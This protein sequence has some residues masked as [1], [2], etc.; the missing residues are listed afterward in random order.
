MASY[1]DAVYTKPNLAIVADG[2]NTETLS[3]WVNQFFKDVPA[4]SQS[5]QSLKTEATKYF[6]GEQ[7]TANPAGNSMVIAFPGSDINGSKPEIA[8]LASLLG[9]QPSVKWTAGFSLLSKAAATTPGLSASA[10]SLAYS[11][12]G[13]LAIQLTGA[14]ASVRKGAQD[15]VQA[16][17]SVAQ[18]SVSKEDLTKAIANA[19]FDALDKAQLRD[20]SILLAGNGI[21]NGGKPL[22]I[23]S[24]SQTFDAVTADKLT[25]VS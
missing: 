3:R 23:A 18:G 15:T 19:K 14:A 13:L 5:G 16:L 22:D 6:G 11:D 4:S 25:T 8:V 24:I 10:S 9:N 7:R 1:A 17:K 2:A 12:A 21:V 20:S